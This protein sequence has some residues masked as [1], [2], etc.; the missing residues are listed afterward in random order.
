MSTPCEV[1]CNSPMPLAPASAQRSISRRASSPQAGWTAQNAMMRRGKSGRRVQ[2]AIVRLAGYSEVAPAIAES[3]RD[4]H[5]VLIHRRD[6]FLRRGHP[7]ALAEERGERRVAPGNL[8]AAFAERG[9]QQMRM[10]INDH[11]RSMLQGTSMRSETAF[12]QWAG[13]VGVARRARG[14]N[15][16]LISTHSDSF[17]VSARRGAEWL[18]NGPPP[19]QGTCQP[20]G[21]RGSLLL[22]HL[23]RLS[24]V[25]RSGKLLKWF[26]LVPFRPI[27]IVCAGTARGITNVYRQCRG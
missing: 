21:L 19:R 13:V 24:E 11:E 3:N 1:G 17:F 27:P 4:V 9:R 10:P 8:V 23:V 14:W 16:C 12:E 6:E 7:P 26:H 18:A 15:F 25:R 2:E 22:S 20:K 5:A